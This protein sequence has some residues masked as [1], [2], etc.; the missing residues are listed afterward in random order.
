MKFPRR[1][2]LTLGALAWLCASTALAAFWVDHE[3]RN[4]LAQPDFEGGTVSLRLPAVSPFP[5]VAGGW[6][7]RGS[8]IVPVMR[9]ARPAFEGDRSVQIDT[10]SG[11]PSH[12]LQDVPLATRSFRLQF[13]VQRLRGR[14][15]LRLLHGWDRMD[16]AASDAALSLEFSA[17]R[18]RVTTPV[19]TWLVDAPLSAGA[20]LRIGV[21]ADAR[22]QLI[23]LWL[24][25]RLV[26]S[27]PG[28][29]DQAPQTLIVGA[30]A[31]NRA[32]R[33]RYDGFSLYRLAEIELAELRRDVHQWVAAAE[34]PFVLDRLDAAAVALSRGAEHLAAPELRAA[35]RLLQGAATSSEV[36]ASTESVLRLIVAQ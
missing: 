35:L 24:D 32:S 5:L 2:I 8:G 16:P 22:E 1:R 25:E 17:N 27:L 11:S 3:P 4:L 31:D 13:A 6:G 7:A 10:S 19:G 30:T 33:Y 23:H 21:V 14:Q 28:T 9:G 29:L 18:L 15:A 26:A 12:L 36:S 34:L 20:W